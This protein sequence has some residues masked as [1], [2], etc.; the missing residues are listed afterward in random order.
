MRAREPD[1]AGTVERDGV[2]V[3][4]DLYGDDLDDAAGRPWLVLFTSWAIVHMRQWKFQVPY[5]ARSFRVVTVEGRGNG[6]ADRPDREEAYADGEYADDALAVMDELGIDRAVLIGLSMGARHALQFAARY[7]ERSAGVV[8]IGAAY[9][10]TEPP[11][12]DVARERYEGWQKY[13]RHHWLAD[14]PD[15]AEFF[16]DAIFPEPHSIKQR[17]DGVSWALETDGRTLVHTRTARARSTA[18][19]AQADC[20]RVRCP[21]L[22]VHGDDDAIVPH[23]TGARIAR[24]TGGTLVT[25]HGGG[26]GVP[27]REPVLTNRLIRDFVGRCLPTPPESRTW[28]RA[29]QRPRRALYVSSPIGLGHV[30]RDLAIADALRELHPDLEIEW[31]TQHPVTR[32]LEERGERV[33]PASAL[34]GSESAHVEAESGEHDLHVFQA[35]RRM[36]EILLANFMVFA[37]LVEQEHYD[38]WIADEGWD[39]DAFLHDNPELKRT[40]Y[41]WLTDFTGWLPMADGGAAEER[42]TADWNEERIERGRRYPRLRDRSVFVGSADDVVDLPL[43]P[44]LPTA[45]EWARERYDFGGYVLPAFPPLDREELRAR[46]GYAPDE[47]VVVVTVGGSGVGSPLLRRVAESFPFAR[48]QVPGLRMVLVTGPRID[49]ASVRAPAGVE[50]RG[51]LPDLRRHLEA[52]DLAVVQGGLSTTMELTAARRPFVYNPL[53]HH[54]EQQIHVPHR[55]DRYRAGRRLDYAEAAEPERLAEVIADEVGRPVDYRPVE[56]DGAARTARLLSELL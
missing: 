50:V 36:D 39:V 19:E 25:V 43:G 23:A 48:K 38:L 51:Y 55:L 52:C 6:R 17:E 53:Q 42:L 10:S 46:L 28:T 29:R 34:L 2:R 47:R 7:P 40:A 35:V 30:H 5:L 24:W 13:N 31:L 54:F 27:L 41:A 12:F 1:L 26:H 14:Y 44:G 37:D 20:E 18:A 15:F 3:G 22:V 9:P 33:H 21:V 49:P 4:Y 8:A 56:T 45:R 11:D 32:V 16:V